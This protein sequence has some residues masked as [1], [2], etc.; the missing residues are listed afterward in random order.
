MGPA[1]PGNIPWWQIKQWAEDHDMTLGQRH[2]LDICFQRMDEVYRG[3][4]AE[5]QKE[6]VEIQKQQKVGR[7]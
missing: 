2:M 5:Q 1:V 6:Q 3:W 4:M 7:R